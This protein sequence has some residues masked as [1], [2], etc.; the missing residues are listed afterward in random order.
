MPP[1]QSIILKNKPLIKKAAIIALLLAVI[2]TG[3]F[4][5]VFLNHRSRNKIFQGT[6][7][8]QPRSLISE[9]TLVK[10]NERSAFLPVPGTQFVPDAT[11]I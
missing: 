5:G 3:L 6:F 8:C 10:I 9:S 7:V 4:L 11:A 2:A 1:Q